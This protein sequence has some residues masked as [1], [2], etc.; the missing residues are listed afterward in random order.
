MRHARRKRA[1]GSPIKSFLRLLRRRTLPRTFQ[2]RSVSAAQPSA[3]PV[4]AFHHAAEHPPRD[5]SPRRAARPRRDSRS[6]QLPAPR[7]PNVR[8]RPGVAPR[9]SRAPRRLARQSH[10]PHHGVRAAR[11]R[12]A[13]AGARRGLRRALS[14]GSRAGGFWSAEQGRR[15]P[16]VRRERRGAAR[17]RGR[18]SGR[19]RS[20]AAAAGAR[21]RRLGRGAGPAGGALCAPAGWAKKLTRIVLSH[22]PDA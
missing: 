15:P 16:R 12:A 6:R 9:A 11:G 8:G 21:R 2:T 18:R 3:R 1:P 5:R 13:R 10:P 4:D 14:P 7:A 19:R 22:V 17:R 20:R